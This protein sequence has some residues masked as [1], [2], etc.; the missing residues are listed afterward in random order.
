VIATRRPDRG[1]AD[2]LRPRPIT[3]APPG[4]EQVAAGLDK[5]MHAARDLFGLDALSFRHGS[6][7]ARTL[8]RE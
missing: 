7:L 3:N 8:L 1:D 4:M 6:S 5:G 2:R